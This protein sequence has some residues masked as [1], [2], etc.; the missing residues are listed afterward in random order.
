MIGSLILSHVIWKKMLIKAEMSN[1][2]SKP[3]LRF[4]GGS[5]EGA[6]HGAGIY[7]GLQYISKTI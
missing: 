4:H 6:G 5:N 7:S 2:H 1:K 3:D